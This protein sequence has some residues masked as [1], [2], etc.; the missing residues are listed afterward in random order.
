[1]KNFINKNMKWILLLIPLCIFIFIIWTSLGTKEKPTLSPIKERDPQK[2]E[3]LMKKD[4]KV[5]KTIPESGTDEPKISP[6]IKMTFNKDIDISSIKYN[7]T[8]A[9]EISPES[10]EH[11]P[12]ELIIMPLKTPW[13]ED[14]RYEINITYLE[15]KEGTLLERPIKYI[16]FFN[17]PEIIE[18]GESGMILR[19]E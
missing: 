19:Q 5:V 15:S 11:S 17:P 10:Y 14:T 6:F 3:P 9:F 18:S 2:E 12:R 1:M 8:P 4:L 7:V 16:F 13:K